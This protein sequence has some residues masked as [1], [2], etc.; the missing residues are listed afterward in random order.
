MLNGPDVIAPEGATMVEGV[1][2]MVEPAGCA[3][4]RTDAA[5]SRPQANK[6]RASR[7]IRNG[8]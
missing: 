4:G 2:G 5:I 3:A 1:G 7:L 6:L 8:A